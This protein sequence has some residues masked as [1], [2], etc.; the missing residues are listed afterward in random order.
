MNKTFWKVFF[1]F[2]I[3]VFP[4]FFSFS[5]EYILG[6]YV[7]TLSLLLGLG[8]WL[9]FNGFI[10]SSLIVSP[11]R[12]KKRLQEIAQRG[13]TTKAK[14]VSKS[15]L[16]KNKNGD[17]DIE[18]LLEFPNYAGTMIPVTMNLR[19]SKPHEKRYEKGKEIDIRLNSDTDAF[20]YVLEDARYATSVSLPLLW[21]LFN[22][23]Y[24]IVY[25]LI[26]YRLFNRGM[27]WRF[28][29]PWYPW[30][31]MPYLGL[32]LSRLG[33]G[34][35][36]DGMFIH[37]QGLGKSVRGEKGNALILHGIEGVAEITRMKQTG[38]Y[39]N[40]Q[41][42][43]FY[44]IHFVDKKGESHYDSFNAVT[45]LTDLHRYGQGD[46]RPVLYLENDPDVFLIL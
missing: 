2:F 5:G 44:S 30:V 34:A 9:L 39:V 26:S 10:L 19:D 14:V 3:Y 40:E 1:G 29:A 22:T 37:V 41:P 27:G 23:V 35:L 4:V 45:L 25:F 38:H 16:R 18:I 36:S 31:F 32:F 6:P 24:A 20:P 28:L 15:L 17:E 43:I 21:V 11:R 12:S 13:K 46:V 8:G 7:A 42:E 33:M